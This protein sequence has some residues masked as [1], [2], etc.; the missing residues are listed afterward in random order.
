MKIDWI[1]SWNAGNKKEKYEISFR[2]GTITVF[3]M[4][5]CLFCK[6]EKEC[7]RFRLMVLNFGF[8]V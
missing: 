7:K 8:E 1:N 6:A 5:V 3:Q 4:R 2:L